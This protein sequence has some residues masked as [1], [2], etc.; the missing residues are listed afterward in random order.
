MTS[1]TTATTEIAAL[2]GFREHPAAGYADNPEW[3][4]TNA[5]VGTSALTLRDL[6]LGGWAAHDLRE[7]AL[8]VTVPADSEYAEAARNNSALV[9]AQ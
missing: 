3:R 4:L 2:L 5:D 9:R 8:L 6:P 1:N 7:C